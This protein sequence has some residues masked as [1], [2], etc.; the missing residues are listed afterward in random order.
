MNQDGSEDIDHGSHMEEVLHEED[1][2][3]HAATDDTCEDDNV[4]EARTEEVADL[5]LSE[6]EDADQEGV[7]NLFAVGRG[8][9]S[10]VFGGRRYS[11]DEDGSKSDTMTTLG[12][13]ET[14]YKY[15]NALTRH[16]KSH[17]LSL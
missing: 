13:D 15:R 8:L 2:G 1:A 12:F 10:R 3:Y 11:F 5:E 16:S 17:I 14:S 6:R 7:G 4:I 9:V